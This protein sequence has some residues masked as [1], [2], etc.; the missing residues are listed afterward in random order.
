MPRHI[1]YL[2]FAILIGA[3][4]GCERTGVNRPTALPP[5]TQ[6]MASP[7]VLGPAQLQPFIAACRQQQQRINREFGSEIDLQFDFAS[8]DPDSAYAPRCQAFAFPNA[9]TLFAFDMLGVVG[10]VV[11]DSSTKH[12]I[13]ILPWSR[14]LTEGRGNDPVVFDTTFYRLRQAPSGKWGVTA[15]VF[16]IFGDR[17]DPRYETWEFHFGPDS[18]GHTRRYTMEPYRSANP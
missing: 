9:Q 2:L 1:P 13:T 11:F 17:H 7:V 14:T 10:A 16:A 15:L 8:T 4:C 3:L 5:A 12:I 18:G 6:P